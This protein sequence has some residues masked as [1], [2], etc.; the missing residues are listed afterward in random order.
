VKRLVAFL[1]GERQAPLVHKTCKPVNVVV[2]G[3]QHPLPARPQPVEG[4]QLFHGFVGTFERAGAAFCHVLGGIVVERGRFE[5]APAPSPSAVV[6]VKQLH[7]KMNGY[8]AVID[9]IG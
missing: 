5:V 8:I 4:S 7:L 2:I 1:Q 6:V 3:P 9:M